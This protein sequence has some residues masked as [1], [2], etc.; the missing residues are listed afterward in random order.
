MKIMRHKKCIRKLLSFL[1]I[2]C[3]LAGSIAPVYAAGTEDG[4]AVPRVTFTNRPN[5][6]PDLFV[7][8]TVENA[9]SGAAYAAPEHAAYQ[10]T[11]KLGGQPAENVKYRVLDAQG[12]EI[13]RKTSSGRDYPFQTDRAGTFALEAG[14]TAWFEYVGT[15]V[16]YEVTEDDDYLLPYTEIKTEEIDGV[17]VESTVEK[18]VPGGYKL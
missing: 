5:E 17:E 9:V 2:I 7:T 4:S 1:T 8:K 14:Q 3:C 12:R 10:F 16:V 6:S 11:L 18:T 15:G 13:V